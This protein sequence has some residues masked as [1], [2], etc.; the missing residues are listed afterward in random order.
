MCMRRSYS[1]LMRQE[2]IDVCYEYDSGEEGDEVG[3]R[4]SY[5]SGCGLL[6]NLQIHRRRKL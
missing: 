3:V 4:T 1:R 6:N 2:A 5:I